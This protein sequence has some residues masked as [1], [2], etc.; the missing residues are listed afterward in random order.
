MSWLANWLSGSN[1]YDYDGNGDSGN[2]FG[3]L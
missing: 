2:M 3:W 1:K